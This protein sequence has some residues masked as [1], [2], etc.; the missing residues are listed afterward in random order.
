MSFLI[1]FVALNPFVCRLSISYQY[2]LAECVVLV[3]FGDCDS[4]ESS[5]Y[6]K[7]KM[8]IDKI[9]TWRVDRMKI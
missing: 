6:F 4:M 1:S 5:G 2:K 3:A 9:K 8:H 7:S